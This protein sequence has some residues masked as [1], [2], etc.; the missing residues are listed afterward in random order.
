MAY[1]EVYIDGVCQ[2]TTS[3]SFNTI[4][5]T[6]LMRQRILTFSIVNNNPIRKYVIDPNAQ[7]KVDG[8]LYDMAT[9]DQ[10][11]G[12]DN[13]T[14]ATG[15]HVLT[16]A[17][18]YSIPI[19]YSFIGTK[20][21]ILQ[22]ILTISGADAEFT[23]GTCD[24]TNTFSYSLGNEQVTD[25]YLAIQGLV[26]IGCEPYFNNFTIDLPT[27]WGDDTDNIFEFGRNLISLSRRYDRLTTPVTIAYNIDMVNLNRIPNSSEVDN[28]NV[29]DT[30]GIIDKI[31]GDKISNQ[32][33]VCYEKCFD[34]ASQDNISIGTFI[35]DLSDTVKSMQ[36]DIDK[37]IK[38]GE[39]YNNVS[40]SHLDGFVAESDVGGKHIVTKINATTGPEMT[41]DGEKVWGVTS[42]GRAFSKTLGEDDNAYAK[43]GSF[44]V[45]GDN[46]RGISW[47]LNNIFSGA[48]VGSPAAINLLDL[49]GKSRFL[50]SQL[51][52]AVSDANGYRRFLATEAFTTLADANGIF[53]LIASSTETKILFGNNAIGVNATGIYKVINGV[54]TYL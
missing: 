41:S 6:E 38:A 20:L 4:V 12:A 28:I 26:A 22:D 18:N 19:G 1:L 10:N 13:L 16:R 39:P 27:R 43:I 33:V 30:V 44:T 31:I 52:T 42:T 36:V 54:T 32:R 34:N 37:T 48:F 45:D 9:Y 35:T 29:G 25:A 8:Q 51:T 2:G 14:K 49:N 23:A 3:K 7:Y 50:A 47:Y 5:T 11:S 53:R 17:R 46:F 21:E 40:I 24:D 15:I